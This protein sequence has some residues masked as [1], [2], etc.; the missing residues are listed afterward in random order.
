[1]KLKTTI[2][3]FLNKRKI[4]TAMENEALILE[5]E[6]ENSN[7]RELIRAYDQLYHDTERLLPFS[8]PF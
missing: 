1:M 4:E 5:L 8:C 6:K 7:I 2:Y 3:L